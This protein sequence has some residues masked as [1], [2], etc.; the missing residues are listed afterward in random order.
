MLMAEYIMRMLSI[1]LYLIEGYCIQFFFGRFAEPQIGRFK[2]MP[3]V[4]G[5]AWI[6]IR[7]VRGALFRETDSVTLIVELLFTTVSLFVF[8]VGWYKGNILLKVF[9]VIQFISLRELAFWAG[10]SFLYIGN[11]LID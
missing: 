7:I 11:S 9:L 8:S 6:L 4:T 3:W 1:S 10:Y 5:I 2:N